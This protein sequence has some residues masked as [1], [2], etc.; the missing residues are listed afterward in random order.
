MEQE[1]IILNP[2]K[3]YL[4]GLLCGRGHIYKND[5]KL[6]IEFAHKNST[7]SGIA[8]CPVC[9]WLATEKKVDNPSGDLFCKKCKTI[10]SATVKRVY[11]QKKSTIASI[12]ENIVPFIQS[13]Y[14]KCSYDL[15]GNDHMTY[16]IIDFK[17]DRIGFSE[18]VN[19][20]NG[21]MGF[22]SFEIPISIWE[23]EI[24]NQVEFLNGLLDVAGFFNSGGW[25]NR[26]GQ[27]G[28]GRMRGYFQIVRNW[29]MPVQ[30]CNFIK[31]KFQ[32]PIHTIDW[33]HPNIRDSGLND[34]YESNPL[35][36][37]REKTDFLLFT[38]SRF[39]RK[40]Q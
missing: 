8:H 34:Y 33:G 17:K 23:T 1:P 9:G 36:W 3:S 2:I 40:S 16:L 39:F 5:L 20:M 19:Q 30:I 38:G 24:E 10:V 12:W 22:D 18:I 26:I 32:L 25:L 15:V 27:N 28:E 14:I 37:S 4:I 11:E 29:K 6:I 13:H 35:S 21:K 7:I 31:I